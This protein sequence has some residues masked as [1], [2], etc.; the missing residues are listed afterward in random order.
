MP[1][2]TMSWRDL[3]T[4]GYLVLFTTL[5]F[6]VVLR[7]FRGNIVLFWILASPGVILHELAHW[8]VAFV[9]LGPGFIQLWPRRMGSAWS[10]GRVP[11]HNPAWYNAAF[12]GLAPLL[13]IPL[14]YFV[15]RY[16]TPAALHWTNAWRVP[17][18]A[19]LAAECLLE[20]VPSWPDLRMASKQL[21]PGLILGAIAYFVW[22]K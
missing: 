1:G 17:V 16:G 6:W 22:R 21:I 13:L 2:A 10:L 9:T 3:S 14:A 8:M 20:C 7:W 5:V 19:F 12:I 18:T 11:I 4:P 15:F